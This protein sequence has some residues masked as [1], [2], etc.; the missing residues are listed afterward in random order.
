MNCSVP[1][2]PNQPPDVAIP[3]DAVRAAC[4]HQQIQGDGKWWRCVNCDAGWPYGEQLP[5]LEPEPELV[6]VHATPA[7]TFEREPRMKALVHL[8]PT[9][10]E[11]FEALGWLAPAEE[12]ES[13]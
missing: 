7:T 3:V 4:R 11:Q 6:A 5:L 2:C 8:C 9:H 1:N 12:E 10:R 13:T